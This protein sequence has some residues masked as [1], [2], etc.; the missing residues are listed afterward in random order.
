MKKL[1]QNELLAKIH[2]YS[3]QYNIT[4]QI[5]DKCVPPPCTNGGTCIIQNGQPHCNCLNGFS[6][7]FCEIS[8]LNS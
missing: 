8:E 3:Y 6:G 7:P 4:L 2:R 5:A 1:S